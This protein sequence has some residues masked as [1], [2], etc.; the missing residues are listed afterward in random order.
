[1]QL[2]FYSSFVPLA[3]LYKGLNVTG[4]MTKTNKID[5]DAKKAAAARK[6]TALRGKPLEPSEPSQQGVERTSRQQFLA[7]K[8]AKEREKKEGKLWHLLLGT[9]EKKSQLEEDATA[10][11]KKAKMSKGKGIVV[12]RDR[13]KTPTVE[14]LYHHLAKGVSWVPTRFADTKMMEELGIEEDVR[15]MLKHMKMENFYFMAYPTHV[16]PSCQFLA[17]LE[18]SFY[19]VEHVRQGWG[20]IKF[21]VNGKNHFMSFKDIG[22]MMGLEDNEDPAL[23]R[24]KKLPTGVWRVISGNP[25]AT[26][27]DKN[28]TIRHPAVRYLHRILV[29]TLYPRKEPGTVNEEELRLLYRAVR[30]NVTPEQ[31][32]EFEE[33]DEMKFPT[34]DVGVKIGHDGINV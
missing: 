7:A 19:E 21:K 27:H 5:M 17:T 28:S 14:E 12:E 3:I 11:S 24:F 16:E 4:T 6:E 2:H 25:H 34:T 8:K 9:K 15:T 18:A 22:A 29:H 20:K 23:P 1:L 26:G 30:D 32:E 10:P 31:L 13:S 33:I